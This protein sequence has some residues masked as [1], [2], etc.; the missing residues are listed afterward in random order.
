[1][2]I[3]TGEEM[4][5]IDRIVISD[6]GVSSLSLM[7]LAGTAVAHFVMG[8]IEPKHVVVITG[9]GNNAGDGFVATRLLHN[10]G[11]PVTLVM[12]SDEGG[13]SPDALTNYHALSPDISRF[14]CTMGSQV[15][16]N[17]EAEDCIIDAILG[18]GVKGEVT[19]LFREAIEAVNNSGATVVAVDI[20]SGLPADEEYF[21]G[22]CVHAD[23]TVTFG[24]PKLGMMQYPA[25][26]WCGEVI[27]ASIGFP[28]DLLTAPSP[29]KCYLI[30]PKMAREI[31]PAR[32]P[33]SHKGT[34]GSVLVVAGSVGMTGAATLTSLAAAR[35][36]VGIVF[37]AIPKSLNPILEV[38][39]TEPI[40][41]PLPTKF[42][43]LP[44]TGMLDGILEKSAHVNSLAI[45]PGLGRTEGARNLTR[46]IYAR[47]VLPLVLDADG[48]NAFQGAVNLLKKRDAP[49]ILTPHPGELA[50]LLGMGVQEIQKRRISVARGFARDYNVILVLK[51]ARTVIAS[52]SG[53]VFINR[54]GDT[55]LSKGGSGDLLTG[56][57]GG[58]LAQG[59]MPLKAA[60]LGV[61]LHG[62]A[63]EKTSAIKTERAAL[64]TDVLDAI[65]L[66]FNELENT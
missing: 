40:T 1:M 17:F 2:K 13:L 48:V 6:R 61:Y 51:G 27:V 9:R 59:V 23:Y 50:S 10:A 60:I 37:L 46:E 24:L 25:A 19:G 36:G 52:P 22:L 38:K 8:K 58:F 41:I 54:T 3:V 14:I 16:L 31:L 15:A 5:E 33:H 39:L 42:E 66:A 34:F 12:L 29:T 47:T 45:G 26:G 21:D 63:G 32:P 44:D 65:P 4:R 11:V 18:T 53:D 30:T 57:I 56:L 62:L 20:P 35:S 55:A 49:A 43:G 64:P 28:E 7:E